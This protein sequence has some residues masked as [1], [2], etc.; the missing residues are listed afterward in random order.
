MAT[1]GE[2][3]TAP[4]AGWRRYDAKLAASNIQ[5]NGTWGADT[6]DAGGT[7]YGGGSTYS[8]FGGDSIAFKAKTTRLRMTAKTNSSGRSDKIDVLVDGELVHT[9]SELTGLAYQRLVFDLSGFSDE[10][11]D[12]KIVNSATNGQGIAVDAIDID[13]AGRI[14]HP[15]E[16][17]DIE[18][19]VA[20]K[21]IR[22]N[23]VATSNAFGVISGLGE[24]INNFLA[25]SP[26]TAPNGD[27]YFIMVEEANDKRKLIADRNI[28]NNISWD[29]LN[30][31]GVATAS[32]LPISF[33]NESYGLSVRL[34]TG[35][36]STTDKDNE[37][38][39]YIAD[40]SIWNWSGAYSFTSTTNPRNSAERVYRGYVAADGFYSG[41]TFTTAQ[42]SITTGFRPVL[43]IETLVII[44]RKYLIKDGED[45][46]AYSDG[47]SVI[48]QAPATE[49]MFLASGMSSINT[50]PSSA[51]AELQN[52]FSVLEYIDTKEDAPSSLN[53]SYEDKSQIQRTANLTAVPYPQLLISN[54]DVTVEELSNMRIDYYF[55]G[56]GDIKI[57]AS[58]NSGESWTGREA[59]SL[60]D[61]NSIKQNGWIANE[62]V[63]LSKEQLAELF[64]N[65]NV[66]LAFYLEQTQTSDVA[67]INDVAVT[68]LEYKFSPSLVDAH[69]LFDTLVS[70]K[71]TFFVSR[72]DGADWIEVSPDTFV[73]LDTL[74]EGKELRVKAVLKNGLEL[75]G[76][77]FSWI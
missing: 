50:I 16:V 53:V 77:S 76:I 66:R 19:L 75:H 27:F 41:A 43:I 68:E 45:M 59:V 51:W 57:I 60:D 25:Y 29:T 49:E 61:L 47:W 11:H 17:T 18:E 12:I 30:N 42:M 36:T 64:P 15:D 22:A 63:A 74:P 67:S 70:E 8:T 7:H 2:S 54:A 20:G 40:N 13:E 1:V 24:E 14:L 62:I 56:V 4:E 23:Y 5:F 6:G 33:E 44:T 39:K 37:W 34:M 31:A 58:G 9:F 55:S 3:L 71:P 46:K 38:D 52:T 35:G 69:I 28:Q 48:G 72:N 21:R 32:G 73:K 65:G 10:L 26:V